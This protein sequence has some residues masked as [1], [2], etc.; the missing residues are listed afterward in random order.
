[1]IHDQDQNSTDLQKAIHLAERANSKTLTLIGAIGTRI[2]HTLASI[3]S[4]SHTKIPARI[5]NQ[6]N[7][8]YAVEKKITLKGKKGD[9][10]SVIP[11]SD[12]KG[13]TYKG[14]RWGVK[15]LNA[16]SGWIG[17]SNEMAKS[18]A[19]ITLKRGKIIVIKSRE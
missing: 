4:L 1:M 6:N 5:V 2:D 8:I 17:S 10:V 16:A 13:L 3:L 7:D 11:F 14:L 19:K 18:I 15:N 12:V 9:I